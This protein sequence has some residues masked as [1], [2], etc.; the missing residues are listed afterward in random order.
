M[1]FIKELNFDWKV[2]VYILLI[3]IGAAILTRFARWL[4][5]KSF[6]TASE[7][8]HVDPTRYKFFKNAASLVIWILAFAAVISMI[9][10]LKAL[11]ITL[12]AGAGILVAILGFAAQQAFSNPSA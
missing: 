1:E 8:L 12:F 11:A 7:K 4:I 6:A 3:I 5:S 2:A 10:R 9:P